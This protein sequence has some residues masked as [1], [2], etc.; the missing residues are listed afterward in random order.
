MPTGA[1]DALALYQFDGTVDA[2]T[3]RTGNGYTLSPDADAPNPYY[4]NVAN[5]EQ[6]IIGAYMSTPDLTTGFN[7]A[8]GLHTLGAV[9]IEALLLPCT[10][11]SSQIIASCQVDLSNIAYRFYIISSNMKPSVR[12]QHGAQ[13]DDDYTFESLVYPGEIMHVIATR[14]ADGVNWRFMLNGQSMD[15]GAVA[16]APTGSSATAELFI[17]CRNN[18][19]SSFFGYLFSVRISHSEFTEAQG[20]EAYNRVRS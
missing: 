5:D 20:L 14:N 19:A 8:V 10:N 9:T 16:N 15:T 1:S 13:I 7:G 2:L 17:G 12:S 11:S 18:S 6:D 4:A 3:D